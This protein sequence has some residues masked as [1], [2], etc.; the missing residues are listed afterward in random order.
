MVIAAS[1]S[2]SSLATEPLL[3]PLDTLN[4]AIRLDLALLLTVN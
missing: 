1:T 3:Q 4:F 2:I